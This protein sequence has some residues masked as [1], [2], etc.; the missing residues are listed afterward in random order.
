MPPQ[1]EHPR[2]LQAGRPGA[3]DDGLARCPG[4]RGYVVRQPVFTTCRGVVDALGVAGLVD[5]VK[6]KAGAHARP[7]PVLFSRL[8]FRD[9]MRIGD[10]RTGHPDQVEQPVSDGVPGGGHI[11]DPG[12]V[13]HRHPHLALDLACELQMRRNGCAHRRD[14]PGQRLVAPHVPADD[15]EEVDALSDDLMCDRHR[16]LAA[17]PARHLLVE[18]HPDADGEVGACGL[19]HRANH[20]KR[21]AHPVLQAAAELVVAMI[22]QRRPERVEQVGVGLDLDPVQAGLAAAGGGVGVGL[23]D[24]VHVPFLGHLREST[25]RGLAKRGGIDHRQPVAVVIACPAAQMGD[26]AHHRCAVFVHAVGEFP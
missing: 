15:A 8:D 12:G 26:L 16:L 19:T 6:A 13:H 7:D 3:D 25:V 5:L 14:D 2:R 11:V 17:E 1:T 23:H 18:G 9:D 22:G 20:A 4:G 24:A 21:E 10:V